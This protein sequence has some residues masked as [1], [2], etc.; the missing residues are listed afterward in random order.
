MK[1]LTLESKE[2]NRVSRNLY[3]ENL[4]LSL[5]NQKKVI[6][7]INSRVKITP[8]LIKDLMKDGEV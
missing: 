5:A 3:L 1:N 7:I 8:N 4:S 2:F 6:E